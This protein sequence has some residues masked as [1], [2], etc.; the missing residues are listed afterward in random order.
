MGDRDKELLSA[1]Q[2]RRRAA[3]DFSTLR[4]IFTRP[5]GTRASYR[6]HPHGNRMRRQRQSEGLRRKFMETYHLAGDLEDPDTSASSLTNPKPEGNEEGVGSF[7]E[8]AVLGDFGE[9]N[10]YIAFLPDL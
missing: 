1:D 6:D 2:N 8:G 10:S 3:V 4:T 9:N 7:E 5:K